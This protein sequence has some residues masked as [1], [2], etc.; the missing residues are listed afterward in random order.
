MKRI[1]VLVAV[2]LKEECSDGTIQEVLQSMDYS[3][4]HPLIEDTEIDDFYDR[5]PISNNF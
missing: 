4:E 1:Y 2:D 5:R 3:F